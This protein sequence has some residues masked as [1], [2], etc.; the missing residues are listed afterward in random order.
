MDAG[1]PVTAT[2]LLIL[3]FWP[4]L[5][6]VYKEQSEKGEGIFED[7]NKRIIYICLFWRNG[8]ERNAIDTLLNERE[9]FVL[10]SLVGCYHWSFPRK[11]Q[12]SFAIEG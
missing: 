7:V 1:L 4:I 12:L 8:M 2:P 9:I 10:S 3:D 5:Y 6:C 11:L